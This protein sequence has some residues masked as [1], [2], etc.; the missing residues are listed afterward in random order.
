VF[1]FAQHYAIMHSEHHEPPKNYSLILEILLMFPHLLCPEILLSTALVSKEC[2]SLTRRAWTL[3]QQSSEEPIRLKMSSLLVQ[4]SFA[5]NIING[6]DATKYYKINKDDL[7]KLTWLGRDGHFGPW[8]LESDVLD[9]ALIKYQGP[10]GLRAACQPS[11]IRRKRI[12]AVQKQ[13]GT[14]DLAVLQQRDPDFFEVVIAM[15][16][17]FGTG[18]A[19]RLKAN[20]AL[21]KRV[22]QSLN[23]I[24]NNYPEIPGFLDPVSTIQ[25]VLRVAVDCVIGEIPKSFDEH[26]KIFIKNETR[27]HKNV[28]IYGLKKRARIIGRE[29]MI[30]YIKLSSFFQ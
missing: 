24:H 5:G 9:F 10:A 19:R 12:A 22:Q 7:S 11:A 23:N 18:G 17:K 16:L 20:T 25:R 3:L 4:Q 21:W 30:R 6:K 29:P 13:F 14:S 8:L 15:F 26:L 27:K 2:Y 28:Y 1:Y